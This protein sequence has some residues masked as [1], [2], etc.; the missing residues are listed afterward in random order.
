MKLAIVTNNDLHHKYF[1]SELYKH[2]DVEIIIQPSGTK[3]ESIYKT[4]K[5]KHFFMYG[6]IWFLLKLFSLAYNKISSKSMAQQLKKDE[7]TFFCHIENEFNAI[8]KDKIK[9]IPTVNSTE[10]VELIKNNDIDVICF[11]GGDIAK[12]E[13]INAAK[14]CSLNFHSGLSPFYN[15]NKTVFHAVKDYRPNFAGGTLMYITERIDGGGILAHYLPS[16]EESD[17]AS[18]LFMK[19][20]Q[21]A[22]ELYKNFLYHIQSNEL[23]RG[24]VQQ[25][26]FKY[27][28]NIDWTIADDIKLRCFERDRKMKIY[29]RERKVIEY[30]NI[31]DNDLTE[32][33]KRSLD[34][35]LKKPVYK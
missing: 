9:S 13:F 16:I 33:Y 1:I 29:R 32:V 24:V 31:T 12:K 15:G 11:L 20:I 21:G 14:I 19:G 25:R 30:Y 3:N 35:I 6:F 10:G 22:T 28:R 17:T 2:F 27:V 18:T 7:K 8:P 26:S 5:N 23:P 4:L 34:V